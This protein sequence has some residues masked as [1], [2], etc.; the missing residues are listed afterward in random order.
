MDITP[1]LRKRKSRSEPTSE[2]PSQD[3]TEMKAWMEQEEARFRK[4]FPNITRDEAIAIV[5]RIIAED[6]KKAKTR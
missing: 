4:K 1:N 2:K 5:D 6:E 3:N